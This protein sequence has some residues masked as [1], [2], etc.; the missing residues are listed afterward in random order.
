MFLNLF[1]QEEKEN[2]L[3]LVYKIANLDGNY[4]EDER[5][6]INN[7]KIELGL[8]HIPDTS[9]IEALIKVF[10]EKSEQIQKIVWFELYAVI[11]A[12]EVVAE[13]ESKIIDLVKKDFTITEESISNIQDL[14]IDLKKVYERIYNYIF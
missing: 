10:S 3:E 11:M 9:S 12:D 8:S 13:G 2:F 14:A 1:N 4:D 5:E 7:Y 6:L